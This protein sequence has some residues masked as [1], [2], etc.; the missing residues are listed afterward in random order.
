MYRYRIEHQPSRVVTWTKPE[1]DA[2][3]AFIRIAYAARGMDLRGNGPERVS[4][5][6]DGFVVAVATREEV[7]PGR[8]KKA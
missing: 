8:G 2:G 7:E 5:S 1:P 3:G 6:L 4:M